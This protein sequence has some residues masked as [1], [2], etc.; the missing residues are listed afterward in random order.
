M[1]WEQPHIHIMRIRPFKTLKATEKARLFTI[2]DV[3]KLKWMC[4]NLGIETNQIS[5]KWLFPWLIF[6][7][8]NGQ[9]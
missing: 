9:R 3:N 4:E 5:I 8:R 7:G 1:L 6:A 2:S